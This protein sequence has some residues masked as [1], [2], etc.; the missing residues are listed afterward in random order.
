MRRA[1]LAEA[2]LTHDQAVQASKLEW[3]RKVEVGGF[4]GMDAAARRRVIAAAGVNK[5]IPRMVRL[6]KEI[7]GILDGGPETS[8]PTP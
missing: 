2:G 1:S 5:D 7:A 3:R 4:P 6:W 8:G